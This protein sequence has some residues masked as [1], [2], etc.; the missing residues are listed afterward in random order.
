MYG[1]S[2]DGRVFRFCRIDNDSS[3]TTSK[4][5]DMDDEKDKIHSIMRSLLRAVALSSPSTILIKDPMHRKMV[6]TSFGSPQKSQE[7]DH[8]V[9]KVE[10]YY[11]DELDMEKFEIIYLKGGMLCLVCLS[12]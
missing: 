1:V 11:E 8:G 12:S 7:F 4:D 9:S 2:S 5:L 6:L 3:F 10:V